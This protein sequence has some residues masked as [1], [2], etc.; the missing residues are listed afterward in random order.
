MDKR[1]EKSLNIDE[2]IELKK[3]QQTMEEVER[4]INHMAKRL[5]SREKAENFLIDILNRYYDEEYMLKD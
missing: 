1:M 5:G 4:Q 3:K 2:E